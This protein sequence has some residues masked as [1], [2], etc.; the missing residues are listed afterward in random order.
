MYTH[1]HIHTHS[2]LFH[3][4]FHYDLSQDT[5]YSSLC[6]TVGPCCLSILHLCA[7]ELSR[8]S[9][10]R[11]FVTLWIV[12]RQVLLS[13]RFSRQEYWSG[14]PFP[15]PG[16]LPDPVIEPVSLVSCTR[17]WVLC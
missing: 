14:L 4:L 15:S 6:Y 13:M 8:F 10:V 7:C 17:S 1:T 9:H 3:I 12:A 2:F 11:L 16:D 5:G